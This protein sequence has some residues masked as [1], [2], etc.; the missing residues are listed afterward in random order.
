MLHPTVKEVA[1]F[2]LK[3]ERFQD[4]PAAAVILN[5]TASK[6]DL[7]AHCDQVLGSKS[8][9][10][11]GILDKFPTNSMGKVLK[12]EIRK[13]F[14]KELDHVDTSPKPKKHKE[15]SNSLKLWF[16]IPLN[17]GIVIVRDL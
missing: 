15:L 10:V 1:A 14:Q 9:K 11:I 16:K 12:R 3:H 2:P 6:E 13:V 7:R 17:V 5:S 4:V 8:P